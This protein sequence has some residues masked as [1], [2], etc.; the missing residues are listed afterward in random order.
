M[1]IW[2]SKRLTDLSKVT[3]KE[4]RVLTPKQQQKFFF[5]RLLALLSRWTF[6]QISDHFFLACELA[7]IPVQSF[8]SEHVFL[9]DLEQFWFVAF[10]PRS[11]GYGPYSFLMEENRSEMRLFI[12]G[13]HV[14]KFRFLGQVWQ[15]ELTPCG[16]HGQHEDGW[17]S[18]SQASS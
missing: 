10:L 9:F 1:S 16:Q 8:S 5:N 13:I 15:W 4:V 7:Q 18:P 14:G 3:K 6:P 12:L 17:M 11:P 2:G